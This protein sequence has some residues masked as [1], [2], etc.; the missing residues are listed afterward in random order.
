LTVTF[1]KTETPPELVS[2][3]PSATSSS[4]LTGP[5]NTLSPGYVYSQATYTYR[6]YS[7]GSITFKITATPIPS[8]T[9][10]TWKAE[11]SDVTI[12]KDGTGNV[13][14]VSLA[15]GKSAKITIP[16]QGSLRS[17]SYEVTVY[18]GLASGGTVSIVGSGTS[19]AEVHTFT[20]TGTSYLILNQAVPTA[21][22]LIVGGGG[23]GGYGW[24]TGTWYTP[25][26]GGGAGGLHDIS[27]NLSTV[28]GSGYT[29]VVGKGGAGGTT[30]S[31]TAGTG[32]DSSFYGKTGAGGGRGGR[33]IPNSA[34]AG[35]EGGSGGG[36]GGTSGGK[37]SGNGT[38]NK[39]GDGGEYK[40]GGGGGA[41][42]AGNNAP[43]VNGH[44]GAIGGTGVSKSISGGSAVKYAYGGNSGCADTTTK[45]YGVGAGAANTG[46]GGQ[47]GR[48][49]GNTGTS[50]SAITGAGY[51]GGSGIVIVKLPITN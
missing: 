12:T 13:G 24:T 15:V 5:E 32:G 36:G 3:V 19:W 28:G 41:G 35:G 31:S 39:G 25:G 23:G 4:G 16:V 27:C 6:R 47:G 43:P 26:G 49:N 7:T 40:G 46:S 34:N 44:A 42:F 18:N 38:G 29:V 48:E 20:S 45:G 11:P 9:L 2:L 8:A 17:A 33:H 51:D 22:A 14:T 1:S 30:S 10:G 21:Q 37:A 50:Y